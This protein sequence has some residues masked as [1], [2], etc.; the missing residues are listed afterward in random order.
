MA[1]YATPAWTN[2]ASPAIDDSALLD[3][4]HGI[5]IAEHPYGVCST[6][7][8]TAAK[9]VTID[10]S[11]TLTL[12]TGLTVRV[13]FMNGNSAASPTLNVNSTGDKAI[14]YGTSFAAG[15]GWTAGA[16]TEL[17]YDGTSW[18]MSRAE[19]V[20]TNPTS[21]S[22]NLIT[23]DAV[24][25]TYQRTCNLNLL[26]N[27]YFANAVNQRGASSYPNDGYCIDRWYRK[28]FTALSVS[29]SGISMTAGSSSVGQL[30]QE[31]EIL[32]NHVLRTGK[33]I[34]FSVLATSVTGTGGRISIALGSSISSNASNLVST[35]FS[36]PGLYKT[37]VTLP[38]SQGNR[39]NFII[40][41]ELS[42]T[43][44]VL[45]AKVEL[46]ATQTLCHN[47]GTDA[48][49]VWVLNEIPNFQQELAKCQRYLLI[50]K[51]IT[52]ESPLIGTGTAVAGTQAAILVPTPVTM[53]AT[54]TPSYSGTVKLWHG[55][56][57]GSSGLDITG[58]FGA[59]I[60]A[61][62]V[63]V[64]VN[65][66]SGLTIGE[67]CFLQTRGSGASITLSAEL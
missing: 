64:T 35:T 40:Q 29:T 13:K 5:E 61:N 6:A 20:D 62:A 67:F 10:Y 15:G 17:T 31:I 11:G 51:P 24:F 19:A 22:T 23:S 9:T 55:A 7:A 18:V 26:D 47:N 28:W 45:A 56:S 14:V 60:T 50:L 2:D 12:F 27:W 16:V 43:I 66:A 49:P 46:E 34:T 63:S 37:S 65:V 48:N 59:S 41:A 4:G 30:V 3:I 44:N 58:F 21:G 36:T 53:R 39:I 52:T 57:V 54:P 33:T 8:A 25:K 32:N 38:E 42:S 1:G